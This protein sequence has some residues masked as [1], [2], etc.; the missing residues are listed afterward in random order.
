M[1]IQSHSKA[2]KVILEKGLRIP[3]IFQLFRLHEM[4]PSQNIRYLKDGLRKKPIQ[5]FY[6]QL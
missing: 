3:K 2:Q 1:R 6:L 5:N 4:N